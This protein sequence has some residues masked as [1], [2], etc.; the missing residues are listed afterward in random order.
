MTFHRHYA[1]F[2]VKNLPSLLTL[3]FISGLDADGG[4]GD[5]T[6]SVISGLVPTSLKLLMPP[7]H[8]RFQNFLPPVYNLDSAAMNAARIAE[9]LDPFLR[10]P[11][12]LPESAG[13]C[14]PFPSAISGPRHS[15]P[16]NS[17]G[18]SGLDVCPAPTYIDICRYILRWNTRINLTGIRDPEAIVTRHFGEGFFAA[19]CLL[20]HRHPPNSTARAGPAEQGSRALTAQT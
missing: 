7:P 13:L 18:T 1:V 5:S 11:I 20:P 4:P 8:S 3:A 12:P 19:R 10:A 16:A 9:L 15:G 14:Q 17:R 2:F 6:Y